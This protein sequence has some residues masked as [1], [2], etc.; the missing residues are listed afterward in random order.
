MMPVLEH[1]RKEEHPFVEQALEWKNTVETMYQ[2]RLTGFLNPRE[3]DILASIVGRDE[4]VYLSFWGGQEHCERKRAL[5][6][7][8]YEEITEDDFDIQL[9]QITYPQK[10]VTLTHP[11]V[12]GSLTGL[13]LKRE[14]YGD[15]VKG[16]GI[17]H[18][19]AAADI[20]LY[21]EMNLEQV[22]KASVRTEILPLSEMLPLEDHWEEVHTTVS[23]LRLDVMVAGMYQLSRSKA[24]PFIEKGRVKVNWRTE[25]KPSFTLE[26]GDYV[27][28]RGKGRRKFIG[29]AGE[30][31]KQRVR[32]TYGTKT[33]NKNT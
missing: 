9:F 14:K 25:D 8:F 24:L 26:P 1:F 19:T 33:D 13:G 21:I 16:D 7:P 17:F 28:V 20:S 3:Q 31:K 32:I 10:F 2:R 15:I 29:S 23:S 12:L 4:V 5:L 30:T 11:D 6:Y 18:F 22:G 27:S